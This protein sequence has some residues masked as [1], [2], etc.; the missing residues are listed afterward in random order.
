MEK[1]SIIGSKINVINIKDAVL[2]SEALL[3]TGRSHYICVS[4]VHTVVTGV[5]D[6]RFRQ[7]TNQAT[8][9]LP[10]GMPLHWIQRR[11]GFT[12]ISRCPGPDVMIEIFKVSEEK[13][14]THYFYGGSQ[15]TL[16]LLNEKLKK[17]YPKLNI[18]GMFSPPFRKLTIEEDEKIIEEINKLDPDFIWVG[19]GA[20]KQE[21][22]MF[23]HVN[24][25][26]SSIMYGVGAAFNFQ[27]GTIQ[28]APIW[29]QKYG[30]E[31]LYRLLK[32]PTR[33]WRRYLVT[34]TLFIW[35][36]I[37]YKFRAKF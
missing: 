9:A 17:D 13:G 22:W 23:D 36:L 7:I 4:N 10:D 32:E 6:K 24:R 33:L 19:L 2:E 15:G 1:T 34:N 11:R 8:M 21:I 5:K 18:V 26:N 3:R 25:I 14:Y 30:L 35:Y 20:P 28:R 12:G 31:W 29:M 16:N 27:A 37:L